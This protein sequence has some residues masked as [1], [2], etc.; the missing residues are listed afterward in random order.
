MMPL[1]KRSS[2][3]QYRKKI[4]NNGEMYFFLFVFVWWI[5]TNIWKIKSSY[6][7]HNMKK[8]KLEYVTNEKIC[9]KKDWW[10]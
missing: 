10:R 7:C 4:Y 6:F 3:K 5:I 2:F 1:E 8:E 9:R